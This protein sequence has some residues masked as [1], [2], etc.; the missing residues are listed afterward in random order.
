MIQKMLLSVLDHP[1]LIQLADSETPSSASLCKSG[2]K[3]EDE[4]DYNDISSKTNSF[5]LAKELTFS[6]TDSWPCRFYSF[7]H[8]LRIS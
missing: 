5:F 2:R 7:G 8:C 3:D 6:A 4:E 1:N